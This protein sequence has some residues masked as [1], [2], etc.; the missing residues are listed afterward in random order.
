MRFNKSSYEMTATQYDWGIPITF[1]VSSD[2]GFHIGDKIIFV[3]NTDHIATRVFTVDKELFSF[4]FALSKPEAD[5]LFD[6]QIEKPR[7]INYSIKRLRDEDFLESLENVRG[8]TIFKLVIKETI[9]YE[10]QTQSTQ[11]NAC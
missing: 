7:S 5:S 11:S 8:N 1:E 10:N 2:Q 3:F 4:D 9:R 6:C